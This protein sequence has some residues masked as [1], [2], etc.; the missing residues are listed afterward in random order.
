MELDDQINRYETALTDP[1][2]DGWDRIDA[3]GKIA[4]LLNRRNDLERDVMLAASTVSVRGSQLINGWK[5]NEIDNIGKELIQ[6][7]GV[8]DRVFIECPWVQDHPV[9]QRLYAA[10]V[11]F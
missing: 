2:A 11:P 10:G 4:P 6:G 3:E 9:W 8:L 5:E 1:D 7:D